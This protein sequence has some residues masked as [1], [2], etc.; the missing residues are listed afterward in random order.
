MRI[1]PCLVF[2]LLLSPAIASA[3]SFAL[4]GAAGPTVIDS[5]YSLAGGIGYSPT[6]QLTVLSM[7]SGRA[8]RAN[9]AAMDE[10][11]SPASA[12]EH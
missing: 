1:I 10:T 8:C 7:S 2:L 5:G 11:A 12:E 6:S 4:Q 3:E 9:R